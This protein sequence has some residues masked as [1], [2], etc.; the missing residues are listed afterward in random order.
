MAINEAWSPD[1][2]WCPTRDQTDQRDQIPTPVRVPL[3]HR[4]SPPG[5]AYFGVG[6]RARDASPLGEDGLGSPT[7]PLVKHT[8]ASSVGGIGRV[9]SR[10]FAEHDRDDSGMH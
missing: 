9:L 7:Q 1:S 4:Q 6:P 2:D 8:T 10:V 3:P 5:P